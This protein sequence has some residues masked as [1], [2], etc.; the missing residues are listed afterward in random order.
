MNGENN[1]TLAE[2]VNAL[3]LD[4]RFCY[5][6]RATL[7]KIA[8]GDASGLAMMRVEVTDTFSGEANYSWVRRYAVPVAD[9]IKDV[10]AVRIAKAIA[11]WSGTRC[12]TSRMGDGFEL[13]PRGQCVVMFITFDYDAPVSL[14]GGA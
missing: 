6:P 9:D 4:S 13:R 2:R 11:G 12:D 10:T 7:E 14:D 8:N 1:A 5:L 3:R